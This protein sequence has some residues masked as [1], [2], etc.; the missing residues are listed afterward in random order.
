MVFQGAVADLAARRQSR[1]RVIVDRPAAAAVLL[2]ARG[3]S[4]DRQ[5]E[6]LIAAATAPAAALNRILVEAGFDVHQLVHEED[7]LEHMF[8]GMTQSEVR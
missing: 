1:L 8:L 4:T 7:S 3:W 6:A 2:N 5:G